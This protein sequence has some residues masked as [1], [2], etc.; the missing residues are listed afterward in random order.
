MVVGGGDDDD[1][2]DDEEREEGASLGLAGP[3]LYSLSLVKLSP[4][5]SGVKCNKV[6][7]VTSASLPLLCPMRWCTNGSRVDLVDR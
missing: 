2:G 7:R 5:R 1:E 3:F 6:A 4:H